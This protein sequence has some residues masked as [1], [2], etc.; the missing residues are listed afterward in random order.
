MKLTELCHYMKLQT[1]FGDREIDDRDEQKK[2]WLL[3]ANHFILYWVV[4]TSM[5]GEMYL[6]MQNLVEMA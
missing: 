6:W 1:K 4:G 3:G 2:K 5:S